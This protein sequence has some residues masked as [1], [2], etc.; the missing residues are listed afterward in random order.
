MATLVFT[1][2]GEPA[3]L[4]WVRTR[5]DGAIQEV[6]DEAVDEGRLVEEAVDLSWDWGD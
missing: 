5:V 6:I 1:L 3:D 2:D 4:E